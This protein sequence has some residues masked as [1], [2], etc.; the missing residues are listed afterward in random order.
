MAA[1]R[2]SHTA[3]LLNTGQVLMVGGAATAMTELYDPAAGTFT[4]TGNL[5]TPRDHGHASVLLLSGQV[6]VSGGTGPGSPGALLTSSELYDSGT[7]TFTP[8]GSLIEG[9]TAHTGTLLAATGKV[10][11]AGG[12]SGPNDLATAELYY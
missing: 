9:R 4:A 5:L 6:L 7:G 8:T 1:A 2:S 10:L 11:L 12:A 3:T